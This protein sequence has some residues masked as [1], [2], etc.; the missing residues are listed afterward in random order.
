M[1]DKAYPYV[2]FSSAAQKS[3]D[4]VRR[5]KE[6]INTFII[7][8][9]LQLDESLMLNDYG[10]SAYRGANIEKGDLGKFISLVKEQKIRR[11]SYLLFEN[12][13]RFSRMEVRKALTP[14][15]ELIDAGIKIVTLDDG[16]VFDTQVA[17][18]EIFGTIISMDRAHKESARKGRLVAA[19]KQQAKK[20]VI[21]GKRNTLW[22]WGTPKW[23][24]L[25]ADRTEY[26][27][28]KERV[29]LIK[30]ILS[31]VIEGYGMG[32]I[33]RKIEAEGIKPW[34][35]SSGINAINKTPKC[36]YNSQISRIINNKALIG[37]FEV[38][39]KDKNGNIMPSVFVDNFF[40]SVIDEDY[41]HRVQNALHSRRV[42]G[43]KAGGRK[44]KAYSNLFSKLIVCGYSLDDANASNYKCEGSDQFMVYSNHDKKDHKTGKIWQQRYLKCSYAK[45]NASRCIKCRKYIKYEFF[46]K[47]FLQHVKDI[48]TEDLFGD[49]DKKDKVRQAINQQIDINNGKI[50]SAK[51]TLDDISIIFDEGAEISELINQRAITSETVIKDE[52]EKNEEL[53]IELA[54]YDE[55]MSKKSE[56]KDNLKSLISAQENCTTEI[57]LYEFRERISTLFKEA[58]DRIELYSS[59]QLLN[60][61]SFDEFSEDDRK[62]ALNVLEDNEKQLSGIPDLCLVVI[63]YRLGKVRYL[64]LDITKKAEEALISSSSI[65]NNT[66][67]SWIQSLGN[68]K[69]NL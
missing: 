20:D 14:F 19:S 58:I 54:T 24:D 13:D 57:E 23:I 67:E 65:E 63:H 36:W 26:K 30:R 31:W 29:E 45:A 12:F 50:H 60:D 34:N 51:K 32:T 8:N 47:A 9:G 40:P 43:N 28:N 18:L 41:F 52:E 53:K 38:K 25:T 4:S 56:F 49:E 5:Q 59:G 16:K 17:A 69:L 37:K 62:Q 66:F 33:V 6:L 42:S 46:E 10:T 27:L 2:R 44:G 7:R 55:K 64:Q 3:G 48:S 21:E 11:G 61:R 68:K 15:L 39:Q 35:S 22:K 1:K